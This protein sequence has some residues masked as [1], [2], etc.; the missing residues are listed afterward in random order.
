MF[1]LSKFY[2]RNAC[3]KTTKILE[4]TPDAESLI[5]KILCQIN[6]DY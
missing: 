4:F 5:N 1:L 3:H 6:E 2:K